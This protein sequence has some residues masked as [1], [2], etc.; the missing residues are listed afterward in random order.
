MA[1]RPSVW[2][3]SAVC[4]SYGHVVRVQPPRPVPH[5]RAVAPVTC[6][7]WN[8]LF[9]LGAGDVWKKGEE[10]CVSCRGL[11]CIIRF[12]NSAG[13]WVR[14]LGLPIRDCARGCNNRV[15]MHPQLSAIYLTG[16]TFFERLFLVSGMGT[17]GPWVNC[18]YAPTTPT[19]HSTTI[20]RFLCIFF[21]RMD[22]IFLVSTIHQVIW[23]SRYPREGHE[24]GSA[25]HKKSQRMG[26]F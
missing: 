12:S 3:V 22:S 20:S 17:F 13:W 19:V 21:P 10:G 14:V 4:S 24:V 9:V 7:V 16:K 1:P 2:R 11:S 5:W 25:H 6:L 23:P 18:P 15:H 8:A 26:T